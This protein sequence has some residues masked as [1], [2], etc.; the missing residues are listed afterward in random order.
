LCAAQTDNFI[1]SGNVSPYLTLGRGLNWGGSGPNTIGQSFIFNPLDPNQGFCVFVF[2][3]NTTSSHSFTLT[4]AQTGDPSVRTYFGNTQ[5]W[6]NVAT[7]SSFPFT[8]PANSLAG[9]NY[10][11]TASAAIVI[12]FSGNS[13]QAGSPDTADVFTV[14]TNQS[15]CGSLPVNSVQ[16]PFQQGANVTLQQQFPVL[17]G[18]LAGPGSTSAVRGLSLGQQNGG[19]V[20]DST[21]SGSDTLGNNFANAANFANPQGIKSGGLAAPLLISVCPVSTFGNISTARILCGY[22]KNSILEM[23]TDMASITGGSMPAWN[24][25]QKVTNPGANTL[26]VGDIL[27][28]SAAIN[29][30]Y[31][32]AVVGCSAACEFSIVRMT[33]AGTTCTAVTP[34][35][36]NV[37]GGATLAFNANHSAIGGSTACGAQP[38]TAAT[39]YD[40]S[41]AAGTSTTVDLTG[42]VDVHNSGTTQG[43]AIFNVSAL[44]GTITGT[45]NL[46]EQ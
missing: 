7:Q 18:G 30:A 8:V 13:T 15:S 22:A 27:N 40:I 6:T 2:N 42:W 45:I 1:S 36:L 38:T 32:T 37:Y 24:L 35:N 46:V 39:M 14:Q 10:K 12:S 17:V 41:L 20:L 28:T 11:T 21:A 43:L 5:R 33:S 31:K 3:N 9:I 19:I 23:A 25:F 26:V 44:T 16:G 34:Q 4:V 29:V